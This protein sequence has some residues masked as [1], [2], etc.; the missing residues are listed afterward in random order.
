MDVN[1]TK[2]KLSDSCFDYFMRLF[3]IASSVTLLERRFCHGSPNKM[4]RTVFKTIKQFLYFADMEHL[5]VEENRF[6][7][8][9]PIFD[10]TNKNLHQYGI[11]HN[12]FLLMSK[13]QTSYLSTIYQ[14]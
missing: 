4:T 1:R 11:F 8:L 7:K 13:S 10:V 12:F 2:K 14:K 9:L 6:A 5:N 3:S